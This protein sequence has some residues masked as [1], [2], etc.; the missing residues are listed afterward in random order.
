MNSKF[1]SILLLFVFAPISFAA[2]SSVAKKMQ[3]VTKVKTVQ[4]AKQ[5]VVVKNVSKPISKAPLDKNKPKTLSKA[6]FS[7][8]LSKTSPQN[9]V[10]KKTQPSQKTKT[11]VV[12]TQK[13]VMPPIT[14]KPTIIPMVQKVSPLNPQKAL[15]STP[16]QAEPEILVKSKKPKISCPIKNAPPPIKPSA[17]EGTDLRKIAK[18][19]SME[20]QSEETVI[21]GDLRILWQY[22]V[23][24]SETIKFAIYKLSDPKGDLKNADESKIKKL[25]RPIAGITPFV[26]ATAGNPIAA[27]SSIISGTFMNDVLSEDK[28]KKHLEKVTDADLVILAKAIEDLQNNLVSTYYEYV[29]AKKILDFA[30]KNLQNRRQLCDSLVN[31]PEETVVI[32]DTFYREALARQN[33]AQSNLLLKR[34][35]LEQLVGNDAILLI[36]N[37]KKQQ[38]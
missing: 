5:Q 15:I 37:N 35:A 3:T 10:L 33:Q 7:K 6:P 30:D 26:A 1:L 29:T 34:A 23:E 14:K 16:L 24:N 9:T 4:V 11:L 21:L 22:A 36:E 18:E 25:L 28:Y 13:A 27:G 31:V 32:A 20:L 2:E 19:A 8:N 38:K 12:V 17:I